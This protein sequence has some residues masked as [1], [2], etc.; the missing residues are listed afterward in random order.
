MDSIDGIHDL[1]Y[2]FNVNDESGK[3]LFKVLGKIGYVGAYL[4]LADSEHFSATGRA[5]ALS[6]RLAVLHGYGLSVFHLSFGAA[7]YTVCLHQTNLLFI[8]ER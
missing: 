7:F 3:A 1:I 8:Y 4:A 2:S 5:Y 6:C